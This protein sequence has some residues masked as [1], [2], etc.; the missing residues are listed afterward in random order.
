MKTVKRLGAKHRNGIWVDRDGDVWFYNPDPQ[1]EGWR[2][3]Q[4]TGTD[5]QLG[6]SDEDGSTGVSSVYGP[7]VRIHKIKS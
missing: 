1:H 7:F 3:I 2:V 6:L 5:Q 4:F